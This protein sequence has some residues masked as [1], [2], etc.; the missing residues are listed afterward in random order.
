[1]FFPLNCNASF[2]LFT[3]FPGPGCIHGLLLKT[4]FS[5]LDF[6]LLT[7]YVVVG[8]AVVTDFFPLND[9]H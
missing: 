8:G 6:F 3:V 4:D 7:S 9:R 2:V 5:F 1:M